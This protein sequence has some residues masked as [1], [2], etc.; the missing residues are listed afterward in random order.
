[1]A[2]PAGDPAVEAVLA[3]LA[4]VDA[5]MAAAARAGYGSLTWGEG[6][7]AV[8]GHGLADFLWVPATDEVGV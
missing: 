4:R 6:L 2:E 1:M 5:D 3:D 8:T 7:T